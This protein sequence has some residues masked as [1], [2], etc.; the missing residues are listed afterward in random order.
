MRLGGAEMARRRDYRREYQQRI[1]SG[2][3]R[4]LT[5]GQ[6]RGHPE[7]NHSLVES[8]SKV[9]VDARLEEAV[10]TMRSGTPLTRAA[11]DIHVG[12]DRLRRYL[13]QFSLVE[14]RGR[15]WALAEDRRPRQVPLFSNGQ[16]VVIT[17]PG[18]SE[19]STVGQYMS[20]VGQLA[21]RN[22]VAALQHFEGSAVPDIHGHQFPLET[23]PERL[24]PLLLGGPEPFEDVYRILV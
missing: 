11:R 22:D 18:F 4:G 1:A 19:A 20:A 12:P 21:A 3:R 23:D 2:L 5:A 16:E 8:R 24:Y 14:R 10:R 13:G 17:V 15:R 6:A 9:V 7:P